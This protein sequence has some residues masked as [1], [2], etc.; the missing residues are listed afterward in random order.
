MDT[1][2]LSPSHWHGGIKKE[3]WRKFYTLEYVSFCITYAYLTEISP[4]PGLHVEY[5]L[6]LKPK[7][8]SAFN[9]ARVWHASGSPACIFPIAWFLKQTKTRLPC[10]VTAHE[11]LLSQGPK[12]STIFPTI[13]H[14]M[15]DPAAMPF[16]Y[17]G[18]RNESTTQTLLQSVAYDFSVAKP[19]NMCLWMMPDFGIS[20]FQFVWSKLNALDSLSHLI[21]RKGFHTESSPGVIYFTITWSCRVT[22]SNFRFFQRDLTVRE[23]ILCTKV[24]SNTINLVMAWEHVHF[25]FEKKN[26]SIRYVGRSLYATY[27]SI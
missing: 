8:C 14:T 19:R 20:E 2:Q 7:P 16:S 26:G 25:F 5:E 1:K 24:G 4:V 13:R 22:I 23:S 9:P 3:R 15:S 21:H 6:A 17:S 27:I 10:R 11:S 12:C 18:R